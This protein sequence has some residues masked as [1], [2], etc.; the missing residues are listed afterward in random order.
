MRRGLDVRVYCAGRQRVV[1]LFHFDGHCRIV[2]C[3]FFP[4]SEEVEPQAAVVGGEGV[5]GGE[6][7]D[8]DIAE[9]KRGGG[10]A[11]RERR[12]AEDAVVG[13]AAETC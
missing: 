12:E 3:H 11:H 9:G 13:H 6:G 10:E 4:Q 5:A 1:L 8:G 2:D 7:G